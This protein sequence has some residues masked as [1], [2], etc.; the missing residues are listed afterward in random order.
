MNTETLQVLTKD[1]KAF[2]I[3]NNIEE[4]KVGYLVGLVTKNL[5]M[6]FDSEEE[7]KRWRW[8]TGGMPKEEIGVKFTF[9]SMNIIS[10]PESLTN[11][12]ESTLVFV[13]GQGFQMGWY[14]K[15]ENEWQSMVTRYK[16]KPT[17][18]FKKLD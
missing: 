11:M 14:F 13:P 2:C 3:D 9:E 7:I 10:P 16:I 12:S 8:G 17:V 1:F 18:W 6:P 4:A 15:R 5:G